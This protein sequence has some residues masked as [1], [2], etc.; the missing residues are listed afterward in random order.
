VST[1]SRPVAL[2]TAL[3]RRRSARET[4]L[5]R[6]FADYQEAGSG[7]NRKVVL[8]LFLTV[9]GLLEGLALTALI[10]ALNAG[11]SSSRDA[12]LLG[13]I[14]GLGADADQRTVIVRSLV[15][16]AVLG[17]AS[18]FATFLVGRLTLHVRYQVEA[19]LRRKMTR[20]L[21]D[22]PWLPFLEMR[23]GDITKTV[24][25][26]GSQ[27]AVG[28]VSLVQ[29]MGAVAVTLVFLVVAL[30]ISVPMTLFTL[31]FGAVAVLAYKRASKHASAHS[32]ALSSVTDELSR[33]TTEVFGGFKYVRAS[34]LT[35]EAWTRTATLI[36]SFRDKSVKSLYPQNVVRFL[37]E[38]GG[39]IF[40]AGFLAFA[41]V[42]AS[43]QIGTS[44]VFLAVF[45]RL[46]PRLTTVNDSL[47]LARIL[48]PWY[49]SWREVYSAASASTE[50][51]GGDRRL[52]AFELV[53]ADDVS[54]AYPTGSPVLSG[55]SVDLRKG[56]CTAIVGESGSGKTTL[57]D[58]LV[59]L[60]EPEAGKVT[61]D[62]VDLDDVDRTW[63]RSQ[64]GLVM[65]DS[66]MFSGTVVENV[67][68][69]DPRPDRNRVQRCLSMAAADGFVLATPEGLDTHIGERGSKLSG[70]QRQRLALARALYRDPG[71]LCLDEATGALDSESEA[72]ILQAVA[73]IKRERAVLLVTHRARTL[74][75]ADQIVVL[76]DG[77]VAE[78]GSWDELTS[79]PTRFRRI[80]ESQS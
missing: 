45:Y 49:V 80:V 42:A 47:Y 37:Y 33:E 66:V 21:L 44:L 40:V 17:L 36:E 54:F 56:T 38:G 28:V 59:G 16:F 52:P 24:L 70:G 61:V 10:P 12:G 1:T 73:E 39:I 6:M 53:R 71:L 69:G 62:G 75:V 27:S 63:W 3:T 14:L 76:E 43:A 25:L 68:I 78:V 48:Q 23:L 32:A 55:V 72:L 65:Q 13:S 60:L 57:M 50:R 35:D 41:L 8:V 5:T 2:L 77:R 7:S 19:D 34:G 67:A 9:N 18:A 46:A 29:A 51:P 64:L 15:A 26:D 79:A 4:S 22:M 58:L 31:A 74:T 11:F 20:S 30:A